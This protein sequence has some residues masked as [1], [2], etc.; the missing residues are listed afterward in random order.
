M[1][2][3]SASSAVPLNRLDQFNLGPAKPCFQEV[4]A[5]L[6]PPISSEGFRPPSNNGLSRSVGGWPNSRELQMSSNIPQHKKVC[7]TFST[8]TYHFSTSTYHLY[9]LYL[10][11]LPFLLT[12]FSTSTYHFYHFY[13]PLLP[14]LLTTFT[15]STYHFFHLT[16]L[17]N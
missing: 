8:S 7:T 14:L 11:L 2:K 15:T 10:P 16:L 5:K 17:F 9:H 1:I 6:T 13:L 12:T 4:P 3:L